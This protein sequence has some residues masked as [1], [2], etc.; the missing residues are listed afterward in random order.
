MYTSSTE[1]FIRSV[2]EGMENRHYLNTPSHYITEAFVNEAFR[3]YERLDEGVMDIVK[4]LLKPITWPVE[5]IAN[6]WKDDRELI[7]EVDKA[8]KSLPKTTIAALYCEEFADTNIVQDMWDM[9]CML[10]DVFL[11]RY[12]HIPWRTAISAA[13]L[14]AYYFSPWN[15]TLGTAILNWLGG[16]DGAAGSGFH[17]FGGGSADTGVEPTADN[18]TKVGADAGADTAKTVASSNGGVAQTTTVPQTDIVTKPDPSWKPMDG[19]PNT[20][21]GKVAPDGHQEIWSYDPDHSQYVDINKPAHGNATDGISASGNG[22]AIGVKPLRDSS[23]NVHV[24]VVTPDGI[25]SDDPTTFLPT[26]DPNVM[27]SKNGAATFVKDPTPPIT[28]DEPDLVSVEVGTEID[29]GDRK[30]KCIAMVDNATGWD[31]NGD[32]VVDTWIENTRRAGSANESVTALLLAGGAAATAGAL[33][34]KAHKA[35][36]ID[37]LKTAEPYLNHL[38]E[39]LIAFLLW[40]WFKKDLRDYRKWLVTKDVAKDELKRKS[41]NRDL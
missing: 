2:A 20:F 3:G 21:T 7:A 26:N 10:K 14:V 23:K 34:F 18:V 36:I 1:L 38:D 41:T 5:K 25:S 16:P 12:K 39:L 4:T 31:Q 28:G 11:L 32:G 17:L 19:E 9:M 29:M 33:A 13:G 27:I 22:E 6:F 15:I 24:E 8:E 35:A 40:K 30:A 37:T